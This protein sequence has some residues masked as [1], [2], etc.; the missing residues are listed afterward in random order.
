MRILP[1]FLAFFFLYAP[2]ASL[3]ND[4]QSAKEGFKKVHE[5]IKKAT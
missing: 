2:G 3:A 5:D 1:L 4:E